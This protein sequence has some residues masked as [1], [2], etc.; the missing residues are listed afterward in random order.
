MQ[1]YVYIMPKKMVNSKGIYEFISVLYNTYKDKTH[2]IIILDFKSTIYIDKLVVTPL[3]LILTRMKSND[4]NVYLRNLNDKIKSYLGKFGLINM[5]I[6]LKLNDVIYEKNYI[7]YMSFNDN[8]F[9]SFKKYLLLELNKLRDND[10]IDEMIT[11]LAELFENVKMHGKP[12]K[13]YKN[14]KIFTNG[15]CDVKHNYITFCIANNGRTF[16]QNIEDTLFIKYDNE[17]KYILWGLKKSNSTR[18]K[19]IPGVLGLSLLN[20]LIKNCAGSLIII[21]GKGY[22]EKSKE[23]NIEVDLSC[24]YPGSIVSFT[25]LIDKMKENI[26]E[27][28]INLKDEVNILDLIGDDMI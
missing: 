21:S 20:D 4:N 24:P 10:L 28:Q 3:G 27:R 15:Y 8:D 2:S 23:K 6:N 19:C 16:K 7:K 26:K 18:E 14:K 5:N 22:I 13:R 1:S 11:Y 25:I 17:Y 9:K 12:N